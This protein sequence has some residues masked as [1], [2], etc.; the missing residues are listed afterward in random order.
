M[1]ITLLPQMD[2]SHYDN[3]FLFA[4]FRSLCAWLAEET[5]CLKEEVTAL[6]P[7]LIGY[8]KHHLQERKGKGL[9]D[10][11]SKMSVSDCSQAGTWTGEDV[12]RF[13][14]QS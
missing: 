8:A 2:P 4:T 6:L 13:V 7:F 3:P 9:S 1:N 10:W 12:L 5:S 14:E 11:M